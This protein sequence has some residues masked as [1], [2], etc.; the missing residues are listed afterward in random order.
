[1]T[2]YTILLTITHVIVYYTNDN[3]DHTNNIV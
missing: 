2:Y 1:M 3:N